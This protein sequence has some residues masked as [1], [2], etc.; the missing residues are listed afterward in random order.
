MIF[1]ASRCLIL[2]RTSHTGHSLFLLLGKVDFC[3]LSSSSSSDFLPWYYPQKIP[4]LLVPTWMFFLSTFSIF[5]ISLLLVNVPWCWKA[6]RETH[7]QFSSCPLPSF[8]TFISFSLPLLC[9]HLT[10]S[11]VRKKGKKQQEHLP[12]SHKIYF[13]HSHSFHVSFLYF[14]LLS[15]RYSNFLGQLLLSSSCLLSLSTSNSYH[16]SSIQSLTRG[17]FDYAIFYSSFFLYYFWTLCVTQD[18][19]FHPSSTFVFFLWTLCVIIFYFRLFSSVNFFPFQLLCR[20][21]SLLKSSVKRRKIPGTF[22]YWKGT[23]KKRFLFYCS[24]IE[25]QGKVCQKPLVLDFYSSIHSANG[26]RVINDTHTRVVWLMNIREM[27]FYLSSCYDTK[28]QLIVPYKVLLV[29]RGRKWGM[30]MREEIKGLNKN[31]GG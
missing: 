11:Q 25:I 3:F 26:Y 8:S 5:F 24:V 13:P 19:F 29:R 21:W 15:F 18:F 9:N 2:I 30:D 12:D 22:C 7:S 17:L 1:G 23:L 14:S 27:Y 16:I 20:I 28:K 4:P 10:L 31:A 6:G